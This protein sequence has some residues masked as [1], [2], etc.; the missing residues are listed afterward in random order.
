MLS[1]VEH[2]SLPPAQD[3][4]NRDQ[5]PCVFFILDG[6]TYAA[7]EDPD[8]GYRS[9]LEDLYVCDGIEMPKRKLTNTFPPQAMIVRHR[10]R[11]DGPRSMWDSD[12]EDDVL[13]FYDETTRNLVLEIGTTNIADYYPGCVLCYYPENM[14]INNP[15]LVEK[16]TL[17]ENAPPKKRKRFIDFGL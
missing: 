12:Q 5:R 16:T 6:V 4:W 11:P 15:T 3:S 10:S 1:G 7:V 13:A 9:R 8:D 2:G 17:S 14:A